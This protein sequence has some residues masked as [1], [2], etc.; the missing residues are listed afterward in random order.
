[1]VP[2]ADSTPNP[3][4]NETAAEITRK[5]PGNDT[6]PVDVEA[7]WAEWSNGIH[8]VDERTLTLLRAAYEAGVEAG[9]KSFAASGGRAGGRARAEKLTE[10]AR[11]NIAQKAARARWDKSQKDD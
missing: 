1:M 4:P 9:T 2:M 11:K 6:L 10:E 5:V 3:D 8:G 7:A